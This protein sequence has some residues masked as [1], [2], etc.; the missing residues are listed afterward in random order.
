MK[1]FPKKE[2]DFNNKEKC[3]LFG[4]LGIIH[5]LILGL[6][7]FSLLLLKRYFEKP[8]RHLTIWLY[9]ILKQIISSCAL[10]STNIFFSYLLHN[11]KEESSDLCTIYFM[12]LFLGC[13]IGYYITSLY[14][15]LFYYLNNV[16]KLHFY[17]NEVYYEEIYDNNNE[18][19]FRINKKVYISEL[20]FWVSVQLI[21]KFMLL[22]F[23]NFF[24]YEFITI[25]EL[26]LRPFYNIHIKSFMILCF[27]PLVFN[28]FYYWKLDNLIKVK[29]V[30][31]YVT[32][33]ANEE[34]KV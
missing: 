31:R 19:S 32:I 1:S 15:R 34:E 8:R 9:D 30:K 6:L 2:K 20:I 14:I 5:Q 27:F 22:I 12:N 29:E 28:G 17:F 13:I 16:Y 18:K 26:F 23:F 4:L 7:T 11:N 3:E 24:K 21:W 10:Y 25:G 33:K